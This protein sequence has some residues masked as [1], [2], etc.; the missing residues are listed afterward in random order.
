MRR[1]VQALGELVETVNVDGI[2][3]KVLFLQNQQADLLAKEDDI[4][5][6]ILSAFQVKYSPKMIINLCMSKGFRDYVSQVNLFHPSISAGM[7]G[8][9]SQAVPGGTP[10]LD[11]IVSKNSPETED[12]VE[13]RLDLFMKLVLL[14]IAEETNALILCS[15]ICGMCALTKSLT[16][17]VAA[18]EQRWA[19][20]KPFT[21]IYTTPLMFH[22]YFSSKTEQWWQRLKSEVGH[23]KETDTKLEAAKAKKLEAE[24]E[25]PQK[26]AVPKTLLADLE[27]LGE[28]FILVDSLHG[29]EFDHHVPFNTLMTKLLG[30]FWRRL[31]VFAIKTGGG[32]RQSAVDGAAADPSSLQAAQNFLAAGMPVVWVDVR[33][34]TKPKPPSGRIGSGRHFLD[35]RNS[36]FPMSLPH[37]FVSRRTRSGGRINLS[38]VQSILCLNSPCKLF[39][40]VSSRAS[41]QAFEKC[42]FLLH[43]CA[44]G[45]VFISVCHQCV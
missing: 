24:K 38:K 11:P 15:A 5:Q 14:P 28:N 42:V 4:D 6:K 1:D 23:W 18:S 30:Q 36:A 32:A 16:R 41:G 7:V 8:T 27:K 29:N 25:N 13:E 3:R 31:P 43:V 9:A 33:R 40:G 26:H 37:R 17:V 21:I 44:R 39:K 35:L 34:R 2:F 10:F 12:D 45:C 19:D 20:G 22:L